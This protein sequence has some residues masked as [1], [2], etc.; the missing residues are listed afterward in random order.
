M[1]CRLIRLKT[2]LHG[3]HPYGL[4]IQVLQGWKAFYLIRIRGTRIHGELRRSCH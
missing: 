3:R 2:G 4:Y 1:G